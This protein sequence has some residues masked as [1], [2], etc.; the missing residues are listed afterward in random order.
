MSNLNY[1]EA[2]K[3]IQSHLN[4]DL[5][6]KERM[7]LVNKLLENGVKVEFDYT[8]YEF[9]VTYTE[10][11]YQ[12]I[13]IESI[14]EYISS[15]VFRKQNGDKKKKHPRYEETYLAKGLDNI[16]DYV[17]NKWHDWEGRN[18]N[19][20]DYEVW[21]KYEVERGRKDR[22]NKRVIGFNADVIDDFLENGLSDTVKKGLEVH[23]D[24]VDDYLSKSQKSFKLSENEKKQQR[25]QEVLDNL[26]KCPDLKVS[27]DSWKQLGLKYGFDMEDYT[28]EERKLLKQSWITQFGNEDHPVTPKKRYYELRKHYNEMGYSLHVLFQ[29][30]QKKIKVNKA[31]QL[32][33]WVDVDNQIYDLFDLEKPEHVAALL[34]IDYDKKDKE[35]FPLY[36][37]LHNDYKDKSDSGLYY[38]FEEF[39]EALKLTGLNDMEKDIVD[40]ILDVHEGYCIYNQACTVN[41]YN[42]VMKYINEKYGLNK[43]KA[44][45]IHIIENKIA[46]LIADT[47]YNIKIGTHTLKCTK[48]EKEKL[49]T[50]NNFGIDTRNKTGFKS[51]CRK[52]L[53]QVER[54]KINKY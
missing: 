11:E 6:V 38:I 33:P 41:P 52:C 25:N 31:K 47:Y 5:S 9:V 40:L 45:I 28:K 32:I 7:E 3:E 13:N 21:S 48:C 36:Y 1:K 8:T 2:L 50:L 35:Y 42:L 54:E 18:E 24:K 16:S 15:P 17:L 34:K 39:H 37:L 30:M 43:S 4:N 10:D 51:I 12:D 49:A 27:Y 29:Q 26:E 14:F 44:N 19:L 22:E 46:R 53:A 20:D 23:V